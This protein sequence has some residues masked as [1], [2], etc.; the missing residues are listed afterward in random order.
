[1]SNRLRVGDADRNRAAAL[2]RVHLAAG[3]LTPDEFGERLAAALGAVTFT[4]LDEIVAD[5][6]GGPAMIRPQVIA[7]ERRYRRLLALYP[8][9]Y[10]RIHEDEMLAILLTEHRTGRSGQ[11]CGEPPTCSVPA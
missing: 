3:R 1:M 9:R 5:L 7:L 10:R 6:P 4:D 2:L 11:A 8:A